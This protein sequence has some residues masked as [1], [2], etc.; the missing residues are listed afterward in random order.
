MNMCPDG[1]LV[2]HGEPHQGRIAFNKLMLQTSLCGRPY[3]G[4]PEGLYTCSV[5]STRGMTSG[6]GKPLIYL[7]LWSGPGTD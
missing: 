6:S 3:P 7:S 5:R 1:G 2:A 4:L